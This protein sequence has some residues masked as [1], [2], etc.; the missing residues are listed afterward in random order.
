VETQLKWED[1]AL[2]NRPGG[3][4]GHSYSGAKSLWGRQ[5]TAWGAEKS[6]QCHKYFLRY[7]TFVF[8]RPQVRT[9]ER[10]TC[11]LPWT[12]SNLVTPL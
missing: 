6:Q 7:S 9:R 11:F 8:K 1:S 12:L 2:R 10:Q 3:Q 5:I 4:G